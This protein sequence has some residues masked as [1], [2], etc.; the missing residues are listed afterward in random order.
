MLLGPYPSQRYEWK[1]QG[2][3][4]YSVCV[5]CVKGREFFVCWR[6]NLKCLRSHS[7]YC[8]M[9]FVIR[10]RKFVYHIVALSKSFELLHLDLI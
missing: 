6:R 9:N 8:T 3:R 10:F 2:K 1:S 5:E 4:G 7:F